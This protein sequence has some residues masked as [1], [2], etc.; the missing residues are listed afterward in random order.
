MHVTGAGISL[1]LT[2]PMRKRLNRR[3]SEMIVRALAHFPE[4]HGQT[5]TV[6]Y[7]RK[8]LGSA[9]VVY[10][11]GTILRLIIRLRARRVTY[12]TIGHELTHLVQGLAHRERSR[13]SL[14]KDSAIPAGEKQCDVWTLARNSLFCDDAPT[15]IKL[16]QHVRQSWIDY[17]AGVRSLCISAIAERSRRRRYLQWLEAEIEK[18]AVAPLPKPERGQLQLPFG[19]D[20]W[21]RSLSARQ[22]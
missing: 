22:S 14:P 17:A 5:I 11:R 18:L 2:A 3:V 15:Y 10:R 21:P 1:K 12:Q 4:L 7:T 9:T 6:G 20:V 13:L 16:P 19:D 8:H